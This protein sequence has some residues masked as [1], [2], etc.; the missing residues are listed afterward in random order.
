VFSL[1]KRE[2][3]TGL[4]VEKLNAIYQKYNIKVH[5]TQPYL[6]IYIL[7]QNT[8]TLL[9]FFFRKS[10]FNQENFVLKPEVQNLN[11]KLKKRAGK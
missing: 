2:T 3:T 5:K 4:F 8:G 11:K 9:A 7:N 6:H 10:K 1:F